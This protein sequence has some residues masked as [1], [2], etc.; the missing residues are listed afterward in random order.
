MEQIIAFVIVLTVLII[1]SK[2]S[3]KNNAHPSK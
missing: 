2:D 3:N 1:V